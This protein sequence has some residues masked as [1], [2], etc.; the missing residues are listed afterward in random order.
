MH[1]IVFT[2]FQHYIERGSHEGRWHSVL[3]AANLDRR[4]YASIRHYPDREFFDILGAASSALNKPVDEIV[5]DFGAFIA[6]DLLGMYATLIK[7]E[8]RALDVIE[9]TEVVIHSVVRVRQA[10]ATPPQLKSRRVSPDEIELIYDSPRRL[11]GL[12]KGIVRGIAAHFGE[13]IEIVEHGCMLHGA[14]ACVL[15][16][17]KLAP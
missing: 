4:V 14:A 2:E 13:R 9:H 12:A 16:I 11:C 7:P 10:G 15:Q 1:G 3:H 17:R 8:W 6:P 5:E